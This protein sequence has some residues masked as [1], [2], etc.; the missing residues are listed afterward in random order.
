MFVVIVFGFFCVGLIDFA[1]NFCCLYQW[2]WFPGGPSPKWHNV[3]SRTLILT[4]S[5]THSLTRCVG[6]HVWQI[7]RS[8]LSVASSTSINSKKTASSVVGR[9]SPSLKPKNPFTRYVDIHG[10][11]SSTIQPSHASTSQQPVSVNLLLGVVSIR[12]APIVGR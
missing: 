6:S 2:K 9:A 3:W 7:Q 10:N 1:V 4:H 12:G 8:K 11:D 5:L